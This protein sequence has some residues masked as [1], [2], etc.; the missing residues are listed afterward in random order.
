MFLRP[1]QF[2]AMLVGALIAFSGTRETYAQ[3]GPPG[4]AAAALPAPYSHREIYGVVYYF[5]QRGQPLFK[6]DYAHYNYPRRFY[7][8]NG[9]WVLVGQG[10]GYYARHHYIGRQHGGVNRGAYNGHSSG[11][12]RKGGGHAPVGRHVGSYSGGRSIGHHAA[13]GHR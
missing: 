12:S 7:Y 11:A 6:D 1:T 9:G 3:F 10:R 8:R 2:G 4:P 5:D 13:R